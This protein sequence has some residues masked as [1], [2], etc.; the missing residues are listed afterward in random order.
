MSTHWG[1]NDNHDFPTIADERTYDG[2]QPARQDARVMLQR[3]RGR[4]G[5]GA[6][7]AR[8]KRPPRAAE[9]EHHTL[10]PRAQPQLDRTAVR[11][12]RGPK[13]FHTTSCN[14][15]APV[16]GSRHV[17]PAITHPGVRKAA[18]HPGGRQKAG[19]LDAPRGRPV[20]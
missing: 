9:P 1:L 4:G 18:Q 8:A 2:M 5:G 11:L 19:T 10:P 12:Q 15:T 17:A 13:K 14:A 16:S 7:E 6:M 20:N 3:N